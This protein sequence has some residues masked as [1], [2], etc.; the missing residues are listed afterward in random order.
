MVANPANTN[1]AVLRESAPSIPAENITAM[2][3][4][5]HNR[6]L[7]QL[8]ERTGTH[9]GKI[10]NAIIW[11]NHSSTQ[12]PDV[13]HATVDGK[14]A[15][16]VCH[17]GG[18]EWVGPARTRVLSYSGGQPGCMHMRGYYFQ[19]IVRPGLADGELKVPGRPWISPL[20]PWPL[21]RDLDSAAPPTSH[22][23]RSYTAQVVKDDAYLDGDFI[24]TVQQRGAAII[25]VGRDR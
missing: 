3:R 5:D 10:R 21:R 25:K 18:V 19:G 12:Y 14:P 13:N 7:G 4:L 1:A 17:G 16:E 6:A 20:G 9:V 15:R 2:T 22:P 8:S 11:G 23:S 24:S